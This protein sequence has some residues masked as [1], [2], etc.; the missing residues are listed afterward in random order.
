MSPLKRIAVAM[1][2]CF[3]TAGAALC[4]P[5]PAEAQAPEFLLEILRHLYRWHLDEHDIES[6]IPSIS[7]AV[8][9]RDATPADL[10]QD[11]RSRIIEMGL[12]VFKL[13]ILLKKTDYRIP[14]LD[15]V[16][17]SGNFKIVE[18][19]RDHGG[20]EAPAGAVSVDLTMLE[21]KDYVFRTRHQRDPLD[22]ALGEHLR[23]AVLRQIEL[24]DTC[25][26]KDIHE[27]HIA[28]LSP[29]ANELWI[30]WETGRRLILVASDIEIANPAMWRHEHLAIRIFNIDTQTVVSLAETPGSNA[31][32]TRDQVG[33]A[34]YNCI[35]LGEHREVAPD[36][37]DGGNR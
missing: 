24:D 15:I 3:S 30:F 18:V 16:V 22:P 11:D 28:P 19:H 20:A 31:F 33:R 8:W 2:L 17:Q 5:V 21:I 7:I 9:L 14:E 27:V 12:P 13:R 23:G 29:V 34:L 10:D 25:P 37:K 4:A 1:A 6:A 36:R 35:V 32:L 26:D